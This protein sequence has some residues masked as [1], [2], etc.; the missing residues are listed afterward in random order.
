MKKMK[1][2]HY[3]IIEISEYLQVK[4]DILNLFGNKGDLKPVVPTTTA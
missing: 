2:K 3:F 1:S 4:F